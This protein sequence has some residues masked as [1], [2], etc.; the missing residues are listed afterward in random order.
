MKIYQLPLA[1]PKSGQPGV[2][3]GDQPGAMPGD[4]PRGQPGVNQA[5]LVYFH[6]IHDPHKIY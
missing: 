3:P 1:D 4:Q 5:S 2:L 6:T